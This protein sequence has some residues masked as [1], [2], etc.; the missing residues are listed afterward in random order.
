MRQRVRLPH[1]PRHAG[2]N[3]VVKP[4][5]RGAGALL[6]ASITLAGCQAKPLAKAATPADIGVEQL[7]KSPNGYAGK[8]IMV[9][10]V[11]S[12]IAADGHTFTVIDEAEY[13]SC[14]EL[15]CATYEVPIAFAGTMPETASTVR[16]A[17]RLEQPEPGRFVV[18]AERVEAVR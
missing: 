10:G 6:L 1:E 5:A 15:G 9:R 8:G 11:V 3:K 2:G 4:T 12:A 18:R 14:R 16:V 17:G 13:R 7:A